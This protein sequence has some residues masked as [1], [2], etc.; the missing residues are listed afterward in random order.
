LAL[1]GLLLGSA[2]GGPATAAPL[3]ATAGPLAA[4][5]PKVTFTVGVLNDVDSLNPFTGIVAEATEVRQ[6]MYDTLTV[7]S[8]KDFSP[9]PGLATKWKTSPDGLTWTYT[10]RSGVKWSDGE[11]LTAKDVAY[12]VNRI[13]KSAYEQT[14]YG[15]YVAGISSVTAPDDRTVV[16]R[17]SRPSPVLLRLPIP[18]L[19][20]HIWSKISSDQ[21]KSYKNEVGAVGSGP[22]VLAERKAG[23]F[24]RLTANKDY[25]GGAPKIDE[26]VYRVYGNGDALAQ[27]L[28]QGQIDFADN[29]DADVWQSLKKIPGIKTSAARFS[30]FDQLAFNTGAEL[31]DGTPIGDGNP[32]LKDKKVRQALSYAINRDAVVEQALAG[33]GTPGG[34]V[35]PPIYAD[36]QLKPRTPYTFDLAK[37]GQLLD[38]AGYRKGADGKRTTPDGKP[39]TLRMF[40]RQESAPSQD[41]GRQIQGWFGSLGLPLTLKALTEEDLTEQIGQGT[42]DLF[43]WGWVVEPDPDYLLSSFTCGQRSYR[44][45]GRV[46]ANLSDSFYC[47]PEYDRLYTRQA[48]QIDPAE[49]ADTVRKMQQIL[50]EDAPYA[51]LYAYDDLQARSTSFGGFVAQPPPDGSLLFQYGAWSYLK[52]KQVAARPAA[53]ASG[54][55]SN[56]GWSR[57][58]LI[59]GI[60]GIAVLVG[61][62]IVLIRRRRRRRARARI[63]AGLAGVE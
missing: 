57:P 52:I 40:T 8:A 11:A 61:L 51:V 45:G 1:L 2:I 39:F 56:D 24:V 5:K 14:N 7:A 36:L 27:A 23:Q 62:L 32:A 59:G 46:Y 38:Q 54:A 33:N 49:R 43:E 22:F 44:D 10:I 29:L 9:A 47:N 20:A 37:A 31:D 58:V 12:T 18:I 28:K 21:V 41:A 60:A 50:Y 26:L 4:T 63:R 25:W 53:G 34:T 3:A 16:I 42:F 17:T 55:E 48:E 19:P 13:R 15:S 30:G 35:I 6:A